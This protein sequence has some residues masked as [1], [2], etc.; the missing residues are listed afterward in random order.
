MSFVGGVLGAFSKFGG[1]GDEFKLLSTEICLVLCKY[2][3][4]LQKFGGVVGELKSL[5]TDICLVM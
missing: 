1:V 5:Y 4:L 2:H 3:W